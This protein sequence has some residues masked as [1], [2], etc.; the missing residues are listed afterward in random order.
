MPAYLV[1]KTLLHV[2]DPTAS[3]TEPALE[4]TEKKAESEKLLATITLT[5]HASLMFHIEGCQ[6]ASLERTKLQCLYV[7]M[8]TANKFRLYEKLITLHIQPGTTG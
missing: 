2:P 4:S 6:N 5:V 3:G 8:G 7:E 1:S